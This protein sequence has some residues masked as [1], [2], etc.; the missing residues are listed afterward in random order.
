MHWADVIA[1]EL[2]EISSFH[3]IATGISPS[4]HIHL[5]NLREMVTADA[6]RRALIDAGGEVELIYIADDMDPL[7]RRYPFLP[8]KYSEYVGMPLCN[9]PDPSGCHVSY[10]EH[11]LK[12]F[13]ESLE[14]LGI[15][16]QTRRASE[17]YRQGLYEEAI[18][19][20]LRKNDKIAQIIREVT[21]RELDEDWYPFMPLCDRCGRINS[22]NVTD[23]DDEWVYY[24]CKCGNSG[25]VSYKGGGKLS[26]RLD[27]VAR[28]K[29][30]EITCEPFGKDHATSG[31]SYDTGKRLAR[32]IFDYQPPFP[33]PYEWIHLKG[34]GA[35][36]SSKGIVIPVRDMVETL[37]PEIVRY[38]II[39]VK[40]ER[41]IEFDPGF[42]LLEIIDD[43]EDKF[44]EKD[45]SV[46]LSLV[47][48]VSYSDVPFRHLIIVGQISGWDLEKSLEILERSGYNKQE[49]RK[50]IERRLLYCRAWLERY[51]PSNLKFELISGKVEVG[52][53][54]K[55]FLESYAKKLQ[56]EM[57]A[58][59]I[60]KLVYEV[61]REIGIDVN[62]AFK[63]IY[64]VL[65]GKDHGP[66]LGYFIKSLGIEWVK[67]RFHEAY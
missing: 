51:A 65:V 28:W 13:L 30:L 7:R 36:K 25:R 35:M 54:E 43:F 44:K 26:W 39:R 1:S 64:R 48:E 18:K 23:F 2:I 62:T 40:P 34:V 14:I 17:M 19:I 63:A 22:T 41:H 67:K 47:N 5:G 8:E 57:D 66:R 11:F 21:G 16:V 56:E 4:G 10:S 33:I 55:K 50:D 42:G 53:E 49:I 29:I 15:P 3:R 24:S 46:H 31:G 37:P 38:I 58:E 12:P 52:E 6:I 27:W 9:I 45:R 59:E 61:A 32:E 20:S 60:H